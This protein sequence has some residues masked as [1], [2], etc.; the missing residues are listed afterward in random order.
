MLALFSAP[1]VATA[2]AAAAKT[3]QR[4]SMVAQASPPAPRSP[5]QHYAACTTSRL[6]DDYAAKA[7]ACTGAIESGKYTGQQLAEL[8]AA[9]GFS[10]WFTENYAGAAADW[11]RL[12]Q[13]APDYDLYY[14]AMRGEAR[15][16]L[17]DREAAIRD[18]QLF[19]QKYELLPWGQKGLALSS[20]AENARR[21]LR[22][23]DIAPPAE[24]VLPPSPLKAASGKTA[25]CDRLVG[26]RVT[27]SGVVSDVGGDFVFETSLFYDK[28]T[29]CPMTY[30]GDCDRGKTLTITGTFGP[31]DPDD[32][33]YE[34]RTPKGAK[35]TCQ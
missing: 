10:Y 25:A 8:H 28:R 17:N 20:Q 23:L 14:I 27:V 30:A 34:I 26:S 2:P 18:L 31:Y 6:R 11:D 4:S 35:V 12:Y 1:V 16:K 32:K 13:I 5:E 9:R 24:R 7:I 33:S 19:L 29:S 3:K 21:A 22:E 15:L